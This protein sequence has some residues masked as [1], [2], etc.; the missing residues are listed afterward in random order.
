MNLPG[1]AGQSIGARVRRLGDIR[2]FGAGVISA[3]VLVTY[4][5]AFA[6]GFWGDAYDILYTAGFY[7]W[8][9]FLNQA[10]NP[11]AARLSYRPF[12]FL[13]FRIQYLL[14]GSDALGYHIIQTGFHLFNCL[15]LYGLIA[16]LSRNWRAG[17]V[18]ALLYAVLA[19][20]ASSVFD[21]GVPDPAMAFFALA[22]MWFWV[23]FLERASGLAFVA[24]LLAFVI[25][26]L[27]KEMAIT[28]PF[29]FLLIDRWLIAKPAT[30]R[31]WALRNAPF[32]L[33]ILAW[34]FLDW[35]ALANVMG[36]QSVSGDWMAPLSRIFYYVS[37]EALPWAIDSPLRP[38]VLAA[39]V[40]GLVPAALARNRR[41]LCVALTGLIVVLPLSALR[42]TGTRYLYIP[43]MI[44]AAGAA[45][46]LE[47]FG[48]FL[49][50]RSWAV[51]WA[52]VLAS[53]VAL[54]T[55]AQSAATASAAE[56]FGGMVRQARLQ[57]RPVFER[58]AAFEP[59]TLLY[60]LESPFSSYNTAGLMFL[61]YGRNVT[62]K[63]N[64]QPSPAQFRLY[65]AG[66]V[67]Y[68]DD[69]GGLQDQAVEMNDLVSASPD[70]PVQFGDSLLLEGFEAVNTRARRDGAIILLLYWRA[71]KPVDKDYTIFAHLVDAG[72][73]QIAG[74][75]TQPHRGTI[76]T[77]VWTPGPAIVEGIVLPIGADTPPAQ[78][79]RIELGLYELATMERLPIARAQTDSVVFGPFQ[80]EP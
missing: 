10:F 3:V 2:L 40:I 45:L 77:S 52:L 32:F 28:L 29:I 25:A 44:S 39:L 8:S 4:F 48:R 12:L 47:R 9:E 1:G 27:T 58:H 53:A 70:L 50:S 36:S 15:L 43:L 51:P 57:F 26:L 17:C 23:R 65:R 72:G 80:I 11:A 13:R 22:A 79:A 5:P 37:A 66:Y 75:D 31:Q 7:S 69:A 34:A 41:V 78:N 24:A 18:A 64:D 59:G 33:V 73:T 62:V 38:A 49:R 42:G 74:R 55:L 76:P 21:L 16:R 46:L 35:S 14:L 61:H 19:A 6:V 60:F 56:A 30:L 68:P 20:Y 67:I 63:A 71:L 54:L